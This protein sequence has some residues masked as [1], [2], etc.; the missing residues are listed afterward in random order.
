MDSAIR[1]LSEG[2]NLTV[3]IR[4]LWWGSLWLGKVLKRL[5][6]AIVL[7]QYVLD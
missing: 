2:V 5:N 3:L 6:T 4:G 7:S 1:A